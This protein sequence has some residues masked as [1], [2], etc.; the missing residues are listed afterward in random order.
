MHSSRLRGSLIS[1]PTIS[2]ERVAIETARGEAH[3]AKHNGLDTRNEEQ[4][5]DAWRLT[6]RSCAVEYTQLGTVLNG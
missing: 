3:L 1:V 2:I 6:T 4:L 5:W